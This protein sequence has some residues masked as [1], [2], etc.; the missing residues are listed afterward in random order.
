M[1]SG[2]V[3]FFF[4]GNPCAFTLGATDKFCDF[5]GSIMSYRRLCGFLIPLLASWPASV[6]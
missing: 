2:N 1:R 4:T 6:F 3:F 5:V